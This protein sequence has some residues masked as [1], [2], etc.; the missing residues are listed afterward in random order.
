MLPNA[1]TQIHFNHGLVTQHVYWVQ[2]PLPV[3]SSVSGVD[4]GTANPGFMREA[5]ETQKRGLAFPGQPSS[6]VA[7]L[8]LDSNLPGPRALA[9]TFSEQVDM[10]RGNPLVAAGLPACERPLPHPTPGC[11]RQA[12]P[13]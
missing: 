3:P 5:R 8:G 4:Q 7:E 6:E 9:C 10:S 12:Q 13:F 1:V 2:F 11:H